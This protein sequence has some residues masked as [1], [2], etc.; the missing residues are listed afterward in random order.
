MKMVEKHQQNLIH[1]FCGGKSF[2]TIPNFRLQSEILTINFA[3]F[4]KDFLLFK[5]KNSAI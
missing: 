4:V 1:L 3:A 5:I 2:T